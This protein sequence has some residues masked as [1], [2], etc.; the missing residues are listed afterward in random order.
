MANWLD[1]QWDF[2]P[3]KL[4]MYTALVKYVYDKKHRKNFKM[5]KYKSLYGKLKDSGKFTQ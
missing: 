1:Y 3:K 4:S 2:Y 5:R